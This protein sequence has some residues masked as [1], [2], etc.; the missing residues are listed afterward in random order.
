MMKLNQADGGDAD[1]FVDDDPFAGVDAEAK[2]TSVYQSPQ[3]DPGRPGHMLAAKLGQHRHR[4]VL[5]P[6]SDLWGEA[7]EA[8]GI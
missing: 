7:G 3:M 2:T 8:D 4:L 1:D 6:L 5:P